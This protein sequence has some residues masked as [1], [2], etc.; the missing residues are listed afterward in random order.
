MVVIDASVISKLFLPL[1]ENCQEAKEILRKHLQE[2]EEIYVPDLAFYEVAN[3]LATKTAVPLAKV[4]KDLNK[5]D[6]FNF[7][8]EHFSIEA[9][10]Q[11]AKIAK[12]NHV[13][14]YDAVYAVLAQDKGCVLITADT[15]FA[16][17]VKLPFIKKLG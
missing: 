7:N 11:A 17:Q 3:T 12:N 10:G 1:E 16:D 8:V 4:L 6:K 13:S 2:Q 5:L 9:I 15:K 14:V